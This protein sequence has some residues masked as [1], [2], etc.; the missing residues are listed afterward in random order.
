MTDSI[1]RQTIISN[2]IHKVIKE[3]EHMFPDQFE[4][5]D[6]KKCHKCTGGFKDITIGF[7]IDTN[8][9]E[10]CRGLGYYGF[11]K[12]YNEIVCRNCLGSGCRYCEDGLIID[13]I[14]KVMR[15]DKR[16][17]KERGIHF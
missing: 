5:T 7:E 9:C 10:Q 12:M 8:I 11:D 13:W 6:I 16:A 17:I 2:R 14:D 3:F 4:K 1:T 15:P